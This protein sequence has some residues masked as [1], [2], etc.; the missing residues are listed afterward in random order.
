MY[1]IYMCVKLVLGGV[2]GRLVLRWVGLG[3]LV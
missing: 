2:V 1:V 3:G